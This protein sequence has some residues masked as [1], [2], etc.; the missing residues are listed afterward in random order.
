LR[1]EA[2]NVLHI[3]ESDAAGGAGIAAYRL[4]RALGRLGH[5]SRMLVG[6]RVT[7]DARV[8]RLKRGLAWRG[9]DRIAGALLDGVGLQYVLYPS[10]FGVVRDPWF[11]AADVIQLHNLHGSYFGF[12]A[13]PVLT[14]RRP[15]VWFL[16][17][18]WAMTGHVAYPLDCVRWKEGCGRCPYLGEYPALRRD[19]TRLLWRLKDA[20]YGRSRLTL[21]V[22]SRW[23]AER[24]AESPLLR[25]FAVHVIPIGVDVERFTPASREEARRRLGLPVDRSVVLYAAGDLW[26]P[27][28]GLH[29]L[30]EA[31]HGLADAPLLVLAGAG[32]P[33]AGVETRSLGPVDDVQLADAYRAA[34]LTAVPSTADVLTQTAPESLACG[35][36]CVSFDAGGVTD[37][38]RDGETGVHARLGDPRTL[39]QAIRSLLD[40]DGRR[41]AASV[42]GRALVEESFSLIRQAERFAALYADVAAA[43]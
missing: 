13:L 41:T 35:T 6:R 8:R 1:Q 12:S 43:A 9:L 31:L 18:Q 40:D 37:V 23:L 25:R 20:V 27:R 17:D 33:P 28:K 4:H 15:T 26:E 10:S 29:L 30:V 5:S 16:H 38:V 34:D 3:S 32:A 42:R 22:P 19:T 24:V 7:D 14:R 39:G 2:L 36:P 11:R 21:V